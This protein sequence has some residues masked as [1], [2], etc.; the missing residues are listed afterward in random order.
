MVRRFFSAT[1]EQVMV[2]TE[3]V[4]IHLQPS[5][6]EFVADFTDLP[7]DQAEAALHLSVDL[8]FLEFSGSAFVGKS[9]LCRF[10]SSPDQSKKAA[11]LRIALESYEPFRFFRERLVATENAGEAA[12][13]TKITLDLDAHRENVKD[14]L[15][16]L[17]TYSSALVTEGAGRYRPF[18]ESIE[19]VLD[20]AARACAE[21]S[22][23]QIR[24][25][26]QI[27]SEAAAMVSADE[28][29]VPLASSM[30][31]LA[32][33]DSRG[34]VVVA[35]NA[36]ESFLDMVGNRQSVVL[37]NSTGINSKLDALNRNG[38]LPKK[39]VHVGKYLGHIRNAADHGIDADVGASWSIRPQTGI[40]FVYVACS[41]V[42]SVCERLEGKS[43]AI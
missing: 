23:A 3:C 29:L 16:S 43:P 39:L 15:L 6:V 7:K 38:A 9:P 26:E 14:T 28:V 40:E 19:N 5:A 30:V 11:V 2:A 33:N 10:L 17:G 1:A 31:K 27:G 22:S 24:I 4:H 8:G 13:Q 20:S 34:A 36:I 18:E 32:E 12:Q 37:A 25:R 42:R 21:L 35:G 41:F